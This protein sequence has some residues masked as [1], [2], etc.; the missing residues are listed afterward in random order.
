VTTWEWVLAGG[1]LAAALGVSAAAVAYAWRVA[2]RLG[3]NLRDRP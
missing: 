1:V 3:R 2:G